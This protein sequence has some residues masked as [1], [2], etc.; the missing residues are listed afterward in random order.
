MSRKVPA[1]MNKDQQVAE[2][3]RYLT[4]NGITMDYLKRE[5]DKAFR[6]GQKSAVVVDSQFYMSTCYAAALLAAHEVLGAGHEQ[7][8][9]FL[10]RMDHHVMYSLTSD[11]LVQRVFDELG[12]KFNFKGVFEDERIE[13][14][15]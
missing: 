7:C 1:R 5:V 3:V 9:E 13:E 15:M 12:I 4:R 2:N 6:R 14:V 8:L 10:H 11:E